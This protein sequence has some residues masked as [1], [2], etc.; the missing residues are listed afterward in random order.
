MLMIIQLMRKIG[1]VVEDGGICQGIAMMALQAYLQGHDE[2]K[3]FSERLKKIKKKGPNDNYERDDPRDWMDIQAFLQGIA[4][5]HLPDSY[6]VFSSDKPIFQFNIEEIAAVA[7]SKLTKER[8]GIRQ[9][10]SFSGLYIDDEIDKYLQS[11]QQALEERLTQV[12]RKESPCALLLGCYGHAIMLAYDVHHSCWYLQNNDERYEYKK[13]DLTSVISRVKR[14]FHRYFKSD[15]LI[16]STTVI[17]LG[18]AFSEANKIYS[19]WSNNPA[20][21]QIHSI[22]KEKAITVGKGGGWLYMAA[23]LGDLNL[24]KELI[25]EGADV[26]AVT[27]E[28]NY[29]P[30]FVAAQNGYLEV[31]KTLLEKEAD[32]NAV[33]EKNFTPLHIAAQGGYLEV[34]KTLLEK[35]ADVGAVTDEGSTSLYLA[36]FH[37]RVEVVK[38][39]IEKG[40]DINAVT[41][42][43]ATALHAAAQNGN[44]DIVKILLEKG[45]DVN[46]AMD[47]NITPLYISKQ[48]GHSEVINALLE[49]ETKIGVVTNIYATPLFVATQNNHVEIDQYQKTKCAL[50]TKYEDEDHEVQ[51]LAA[52][53]SCELTGKV[54]N[55]LH[56]QVKLETNVHTPKQ[57]CALQIQ[58]ESPANFSDT[59]TNIA[60][61]HSATLDE[62]NKFTFLGEIW[63]LICNFFL[64]CYTI[65]KISTALDQTPKSKQPGSVTHNCIKSVSDHSPGKNR[66]NYVYHLFEDHSINQAVDTVD[67]QNLQVRPQ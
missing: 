43:D 36:A 25:E 26:N 57:T 4:L 32:V 58:N 50:S 29:T 5:Y 59:T 22:T 30:L 2:Y 51:N 56:L 17:S 55:A 3:Y 15:P 33:T 13:A 46:T 67:K 49:K 60:P 20:W 52:H 9:V 21:K 66:T 62:K 47:G 10:S 1:L 38:T 48:N 8:G 34:V 31:V 42:I 35:G 16:L 45:A 6:P 14:S 63:K 19:I 40:A 54:G 28:K 41:N 23:N 12:N 53:N 27:E 64:K 44:I 11:Y 65:L 39:L 18:D 7:Q 24:V 37:G 61:K